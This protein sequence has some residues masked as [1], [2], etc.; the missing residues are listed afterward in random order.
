MRIGKAAL[1]V[2]LA[3]LLVAALLAAWGLKVFGPDL[4]RSL[5]VREV[6]R[7]LA[8]DLKIGAVELAFLPLQIAVHDAELSQDGVRLLAVRRLGFRLAPL[9]SLWEGAWIGDV[10]IE[11]PHAVVSD[12]VAVWRRLAS[13]AESA[14]QSSAGQPPFLPRTLTIESGRLE[15]EWSRQ[16]AHA[17][18]SDFGLEARLGGVVRRHVDFTTTARVVAER[19]GA[20]LRV[21][22]ISLLGRASTRGIAIDAGA[23]DSTAGSLRTSFSVLRRQLQG[24]LAC[25]LDL[26]AV[27]ALFPEAGVVGGKS[28]VEAKIA[29]SLDRPEISADLDADA[30]RIGKV[31]L[32][33]RGHLTSRGVDWRLERVHARMF[34]GEVDGDA[35]GKIS[36]L[37]PFEAEA[38]FSR[39]DPAA[40]VRLF[41][42]HTPLV[43]AWTGRARLSGDLLGDDLRGNGGFTLQEGTEKLAGTVAFSL[44]RDRVE[45]EGTVGAGTADQLRARYEVVRGSQIAGEV[46][47]KSARLASFGR[48]VG[49]DLEGAGEARAVLRGTVDHPVLAGQGEFSNLVVR[50]IRAGAVRGPFEISSNGVVSSHLELA[51]GEVVFGGRA[52]LSSDQQN[53]WSATL[54]RMSIGRVA[55]ALRSFWPAVPEVAGTVN[56]SV[57]VAGPWTSPRV[58]AKQ[59]FVD[60]EVGGEEIGEGSLEVGVADGRLATRIALHGAKDMVAALQLTRER[61]GRLSGDASVKGV[62]IERIRR[63]Q[64]RWPGLKGTVSLEATVSGTV[65]EPRGQAS[66]SVASL[67]LGERPLGEAAFRLQADG[68]RLRIE[69]T[70]A[71]KTRLTAT[72]GLARPYPFQGHAEWQDL[73]LGSLLFGESQ[74]KIET[75]GQGDLRGD[76]DHPLDEGSA[77]ITGLRVAKGAERLENQ[78]PIVVRIAGGTIDTADAVLAGGRQRVTF[79]GR[80]TASDSS[81]HASAKGD[82]AL[83]ESLS[84]QVASARGEL[85]ADIQGTRREGEPW[86][87]RGRVHLQ[88]GA[89]DF[90]FLLG[91]TDVA[92]SVDIDDRTVDLHELSGKLGGGG[93]LVG[94]TIALDRG[95]DLGWAIHEA[96]LGI[97]SWLDYRAS[98]NGRVLGSLPQPRLTGE[99]DVTQAVYDQR[100]EWAEFLPWFRKQARPTAG[101]PGLPIPVD[102]HLVADGGL[103]VDNNLAK[104]E[105]RGDLRLRGDAEALRLAGAIEVLDGDFIFRRRRFEITSGSVQFFEDRPLNPDLRFSGETYVQTKEE[106]YEIQMQVS[107]TADNP[108]IQFRADDPSLTE[109]DVLALVT[110]GRTVTQLQSQGA[111]GIELGE[112][113]ALTTGSRG[114]KVEQG[115]HTLLP[116][117]RIEIEPTFSRV[118][119]ASEPRFTIA[120]DLTDRFSATIGTG[121]G[122]ER[123][124]DVGLEY[125]FT[126]RF[127]VQGVWE[128]QTK[129]Q[130]GAFGANLKFRVPFRTLPRFSLLPRRSADRGVP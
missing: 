24:R 43:G 108:R 9:R 26:D 91:V 116:V 11:E 44:G 98:G 115:I 30:V 72:A 3:A 85:D 40:F 51:D 21:H 93:F 129:S 128:S 58:E 124:Q 79:G 31:E 33:G 41:G 19:S 111:G 100:I 103:F 82:L 18:V 120:K 36:A 7:G 2:G 1:R 84:P 96:S 49:L 34:S 12:R 20:S 17:V 50:G 25:D 32:S 97:P 37:V 59:Q 75:T 88:R 118:N 107:G 123:N 13:T 78:N 68:D 38:A 90:A 83:L 61:D 42:P 121:L 119:G 10:S 64:A 15:L 62:H 76:V 125:H 5:L 27:S 112:V 4:L 80:W 65:S 35:H 45:V 81:F 63:L 54:R 6:R 117:D 127:S 70:F 87:Y 114:G 92:G 126:R 8:A 95:W 102:L 122:S 67:G 106:E 109:N 94:G 77:Q 28:R 39:W 29:G 104:A 14:V 55:P 48:F 73:D 71:D 86:R 89:V 69:G 66:V 22:R 74:L 130:A 56:G 53:D 101:G 57:K 46:E 99:I 113:L 60:L 105:L 16:G 23:I 52:A 47:G 110:F